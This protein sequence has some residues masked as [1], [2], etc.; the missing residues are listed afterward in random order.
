MSFSLEQVLVKWGP[1]VYR[2]ENFG[3][4]SVWDTLS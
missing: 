2:Q 1:V 3:K 4:S